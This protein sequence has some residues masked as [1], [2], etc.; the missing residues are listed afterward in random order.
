MLKIFPLAAKIIAIILII[1]AAK[2]LCLLWNPADVREGYT[3]MLIAG[4]GLLMEQDSV[5]LEDEN[6]RI[7]RTS[8]AT[9]REGKCAEQAL[10]RIIFIENK[11]QRRVYYSV[12]GNYHPLEEEANDSAVVRAYRCICYQLG[13]WL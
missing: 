6:D 11:E 1:F 3:G 9:N 5:C 12:G 2:A 4:E 7:R 10:A 13:H 8:I